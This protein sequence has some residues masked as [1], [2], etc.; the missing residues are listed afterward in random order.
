MNDLFTR[1]LLIEEA[2][3][4]AEDSK[5]LVGD[6]LAGATWTQAQA[7]LYTLIAIADAL[8]ALLR[9]GLTVEKP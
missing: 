6:N 4:L 7:Q 5:T 9:N 1:Q 8:D 2:R 3:N